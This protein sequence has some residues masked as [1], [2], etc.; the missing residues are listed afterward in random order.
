MQAALAGQGV[1][2]ARVALVS[3]P[4]ERGDLV[5]PFGVAGRLGSPFA[6]WLIV[7][8]SS[9]GRDEVRQFCAWVEAQAALTRGVLGELA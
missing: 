5:E 8:S 6:Y 1:A 4:L 7:N 9:A 2:L 3:E